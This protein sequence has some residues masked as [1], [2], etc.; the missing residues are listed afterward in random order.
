M[1]RWICQCGIDERSVRSKIRISTIR[2]PALNEKIIECGTVIGT[3][4]IILLNTIGLKRKKQSLKNSEF[5]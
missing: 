5:N 1:F 4:K 3:P 2:N